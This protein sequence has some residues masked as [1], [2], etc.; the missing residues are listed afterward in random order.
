MLEGA[1]KAYDRAFDAR[2]SA[3]KRLETLESDLLAKG[4][5]AVEAGHEIDIIT[6]EGNSPRNLFHDILQLT[7]QDHDVESLAD[8]AGAF[9]VDE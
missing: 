1:T 9:A 8:L 4:Q 5:K 6:T 3:R 2:K 7:E